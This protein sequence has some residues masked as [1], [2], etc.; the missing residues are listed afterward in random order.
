MDWVA[1][2]VP[3]SADE[4]QAAITEA[5]TDRVYVLIKNTSEETVIGGFRPDVEGVVRALRSVIV[6]LPTVSTVH[7]EIG[8]LV[9]AE[10]HALH[11]HET[12]SSADIAFYSGVWARRYAPD[13]RSAAEAIT[14]QASRIIDFPALI[15]RAYEDGIGVFLEVGPGSSCTRLIDRILETRPHLARSACRPDRG[16][17]SAV[18]E[19]LGDCIAHRIPVDL[20]SLYD[21]PDEQVEDSGQSTSASQD[22]ERHT[23]R[24]E[25]G[26]PRF[27]IPPPALKA[28]KPG[29]RSEASDDETA[30]SQRS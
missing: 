22:V 14:A 7:C 5:G 26:L 8:R 2:I 29:N 16:A 1:G 6:E 27:K 24:V 20:G 18:L 13:R 28:P 9:E 21:I 10:Y 25:V 12:S 19:V 11:D 15:E 23:V 4:V 3:R 17:L 30:T